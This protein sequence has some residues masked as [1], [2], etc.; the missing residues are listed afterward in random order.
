MPLLA[1]S[2]TKLTSAE[3]TD[4]TEW[5]LNYTFCLCC[6]IPFLVKNNLKVFSAS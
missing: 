5:L 2:G 1:K 4:R 6:V 3:D